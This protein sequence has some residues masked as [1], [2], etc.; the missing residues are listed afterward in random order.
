MICP[1]DDHFGPVVN[2]YCRSFDFTLFFE[3]SILA[4]LPSLVFLIAA[5]ARI[6]Y[7]RKVSV[8]V[9][10]RDWLLCCKQVSLQPYMSPLKLG[11][12]DKPNRRSPY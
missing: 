8:V 10:S 7:I 1:S 12:P 4:A 3:D 9:L 11:G 2:E 6:A 5:C